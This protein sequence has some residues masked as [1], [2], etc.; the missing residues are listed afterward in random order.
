MAHYLIE[1]RFSGFAKEYLRGLMY[2]VARKFRVRGA[3]KNRAIPHITLVGPLYT[4]NE[5]R[6]VQEVRNIAS[7]YDV[8]DFTINGFNHF[9]GGF[10]ERLFCKPKVIF[11]EIG[12]S[13]QLNQLRQELV[14]QLKSFCTLNEH[15]YKSDRHFHATIAFKDIGNRFDAIWKYLEQKKPP[16]I[17]NVLLRITIIKDQRILYEY[18]ILQKRLLNRAQAKNSAIFR[19]T[20]ALLKRKH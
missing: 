3:T 11:A 12:G 4:N 2:E 19:R 10:F 1:F 9:G 16:K 13:D 18:D 14:A 8:V 15:D 5:R 20:I 6:L 7:K 17:R